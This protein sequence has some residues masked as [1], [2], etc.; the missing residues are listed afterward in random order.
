VTVAVNRSEVAVVGAGII[1]LSIAYHLARDGL[2]VT[3]FEREG[4][5]SGQSSVAPGGLRRQW[6]TPVSC[7]MSDESFGFYRHIDELLAPGTHITFRECGYIFLAHT[8]PLLQQLRRNAETQ[9]AFGIP[10]AILRPEELRE[11]VPALRTDTVLGA[12]Y[13][14]TDGYFDDPWLVIF[15]F[16]QAARRL[17]ATIEHR[18]VVRLE[19]EGSGWTLSLANGKSAH[20]DQVVLA[21]GTRSVPLASGIGVELP[22]RDEPRYLF[23]SNVVEERICD[24]LVV[25]DER[26]FAVKQMANGQVLTSHLPAGRA[27]RE[28]T[29]ETW[30]AR[31][32]EAAEEL[33]PALLDVSLTHMVKGH[34]DM[35]PDHQPI[36]G[37]LPGNAGVWL[38]AGMS[39][40]GFMMA[41]AVGSAVADLVHGREPAWYFRGLGLERFQFGE[42]VV[43]GQVI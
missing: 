39:G 30:K 8:D 21:A 14:P 15:T 7:A 18:E 4:I 28:P 23:Y 19:L 33:L 12:S 24:P 5:G 22:I 43:E 26:G 9:N 2:S 37:A 25:S 3:V 1:G 6:A 36:V 20:A 34:Y 41:P 32:G 42:V 27:E 10:S 40:H 29:P 16:A 38:A 35:T 17:G 13:C 31:I 11:I